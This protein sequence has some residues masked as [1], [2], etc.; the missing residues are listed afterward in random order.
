MTP[1]LIAEISKPYGWVMGNQRGAWREQS[2]NVGGQFSHEIL[3]TE[4]AEDAENRNIFQYF[5]PMTIRGWISIKHRVKQ[6]FDVLSLLSKG[7]TGRKIEQDFPR[8]ITSLDYWDSSVPL[9]LSTYV[10]SPDNSPQEF[11]HS[12]LGDLLNAKDFRGGAQVCEVG[13]GAGFTLKKI[14]SQ[15]SHID[16]WGADFSE[17]LLTHARG[18]LKDIPNVKGLIRVDITVE[19]LPRR[20]DLIFTHGLITCTTQQT[21]PMVLRSLF[22]SSDH[23]VLIEPDFSKMGFFERLRFAKDRGYEIINYEQLI[24]DSGCTLIGV[25]SAPI[26][27]DAY[28]KVFVLVR[29]GS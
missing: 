13:C 19:M 24:S 28:L 23:V 18:Y 1:R 6:G 29:D 21:A 9:M 12:L 26:G 15:N 14:A 5:S 4:C 3:R 27:E 17:A 20:F 7:L 25:H 8:D 22:A 10:N 2:N 11:S 16:F